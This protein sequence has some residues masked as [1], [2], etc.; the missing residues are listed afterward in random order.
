[1]N[2]LAHFHQD[3]GRPH[4]GP[5]GWF[6]AGVAVLDLWPTFARARPQR[7]PP[8]DPATVRGATPATPGGRALQRGLLRHLEVDAAFHVDPAFGAARAALAA[9]ARELDRRLAALLTHVGVELALDAR[10]LAADPGLA[11]GFYA[12]L[13]QVEPDA[14]EAELVAIIGPDAVGFQAAFEAFRT[15]RHLEDWTRPEA[16]AASLAHAVRLVGRE[17]PPLA[18]LAA[19]VTEALVAVT[20]LAVALDG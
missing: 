19:F 15:R 5:P 6:T 13:E 14:L 9:R 20:P 10:L 11:R 8:V 3:R 7:R 16:V 1:V 12:A 4:E 2:H 17:P 18:A